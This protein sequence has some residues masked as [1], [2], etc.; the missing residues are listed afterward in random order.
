VRITQCFYLGVYE[1][2]QEQYQRVMGGNPSF[3]WQHRVE[4]RLEAFARGAKEVPAL[5]AQ[6][7]ARCPVDSVSWDDAISFCAKLLAL[8]EETSTRATYRLP[9]E[10]EWEYACRAGTMTSHHF[11]DVPTRNIRLMGNLSGY[12][13]WGAH[14]ASAFPFTPCHVEMYPHRV[15][16]K[17]PNAWGLYDMY[18]NVW[19]WCQD[20]YGDYPSGQV[21]D[22]Q[23]L[24]SGSERV[25]R[26]G[27]WADFPIHCRSASRRWHLPDSRNNRLGFRVAAVL[28]GQ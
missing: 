1:V 17:K 5:E 20:W 12:A 22:P 13:W 11:G 16:Q 25:C 27:S 10:A 26:G 6:D 21:T 14:V 9:T 23:G 19:E 15:G 4:G 24:N 18:G 2:T 7:V 28:S 3:V 8:P